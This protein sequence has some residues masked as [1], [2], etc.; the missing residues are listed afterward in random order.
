MS[1]F[2]LAL[3]CEFS[4]PYHPS[5]L[6]L[7]PIYRFLITLLVLYIPKTKQPNTFTN[8]VRELSLHRL[9][10]HL[11]FLKRFIY[12]FFPLDSQEPERWNTRIQKDLSKITKLLMT[13]DNAV[14]KKKQEGKYRE[15]KTFTCKSCSSRFV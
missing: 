9:Y 15:L 5:H 2:F 10:C 12:A 3:L 14:S 13:L 7:I 1:L 6:I 4:Y 8:F 11:H